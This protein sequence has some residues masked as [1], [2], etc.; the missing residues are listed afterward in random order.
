MENRRI[1]SR[2]DA[3]AQRLRQDLEWPQKGAKTQKRKIT[4]PTGL[5]GGKGTTF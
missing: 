2:K 5:H 1:N 3:K 4:G